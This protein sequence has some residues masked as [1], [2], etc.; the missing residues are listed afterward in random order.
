MHLN[1]E[2]DSHGEEG[3]AKEEQFGNETKDSED[4]KPVVGS[5]GRGSK[6]TNE[7]KQL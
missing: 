6:T 2:T 1:C 4:S 3:G 5:N 7:I